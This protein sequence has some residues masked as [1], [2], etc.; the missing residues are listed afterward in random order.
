MTIADE[1]QNPKPAKK[2]A[3]SLDTIAALRNRDGAEIGGHWSR[4]KKP[5]KENN[6]G[7]DVTAPTEQEILKEPHRRPRLPLFK[8]AKPH[9]RFLPSQ[10]HPS[11]SA[12]TKKRI[13]HSKEK[14]KASDDK[15]P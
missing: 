15:N 10:S 11:S 2:L 4:G 6:I 7:A 9:P 13:F 1:N 5:R 8:K 14:A 3:K 12:L